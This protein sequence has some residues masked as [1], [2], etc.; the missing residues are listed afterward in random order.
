MQVVAKGFV[1][2]EIVSVCKDF[3][4]GDYVF[5]IGESVVSRGS[6]QDMLDESIRHKHQYKDWIRNK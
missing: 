2:S 5:K 6:L 3:F 4:Y 1:G